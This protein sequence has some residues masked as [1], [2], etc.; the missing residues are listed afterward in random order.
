VHSDD[1][2]EPKIYNTRKACKTNET[3]MHKALM[4]RN[5]GHINTDTAKPKHSGAAFFSNI[6]AHSTW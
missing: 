5:A 1:K 2:D 6:C 3:L 4:L